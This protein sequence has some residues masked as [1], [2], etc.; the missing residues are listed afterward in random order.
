MDEVLL[1]EFRDTLSGY[2]KL[3]DSLIIGAVT[4]FVNEEDM[5]DYQEFLQLKEM[6]D[7]H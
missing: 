5:V 6:W 7:N 2:I 4:G 1:Q 3:I